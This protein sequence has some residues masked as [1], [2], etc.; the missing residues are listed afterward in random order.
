MN[1]DSP[2][3]SEQQIGLEFDK[4]LLDRGHLIAAT[5]HPLSPNSLATLAST[6]DSELT[7]LSK[8]LA[9]SLPG[10]VAASVGA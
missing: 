1:R 2:E 10:E 7:A 9:L 8:N 3:I 6:P 4:R 5:R